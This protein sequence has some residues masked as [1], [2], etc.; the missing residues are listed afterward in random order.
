MLLS[1]F[2]AIDTKNIIR[3]ISQSPEIFKILAYSESIPQ[4]IFPFCTLNLK[5]CGDAG[6]YM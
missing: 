3:H 4:T 1:F 5:K 6:C 2:L